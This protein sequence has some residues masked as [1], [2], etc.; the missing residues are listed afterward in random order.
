MKNIL[1]VPAMKNLTISAIK[2]LTDPLPR[3]ASSSHAGGMAGVNRRRKLTEGENATLRLAMSRAA[4]PAD[5]L[6]PG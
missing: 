3:P 2:N 6:I 1:A 5:H 4:F